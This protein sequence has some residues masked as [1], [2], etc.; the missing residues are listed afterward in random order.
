MVTDE[1]DDAGPQAISAGP[2][3]HDSGYGSM[4]Y[5]QIVES[6]PYIPPRRQSLH[7]TV[8]R[9]EGNAHQKYSTESG[10]TIEPS[11]HLQTPLYED[12]MP[13]PLSPRRPS[14]PAPAPRHEAEE[15]SE[16]AKEVDDQHTSWLNTINES[17]GSSAASVHSRR[18]SFGLRRKRIRPTSGATEADFNAALDAAIEVAYDDGFEPDDEEDDEMDLMDDPQY[19]ADPSDPLSHIRR[20]VELARVNAREAERQAAI[21]Q[22]R[23]TERLQ[24]QSLVAPRNSLDGYGD[25]EG[26]EEER[27]LEEW[28]RDFVLDDTEYSTQ[29]K[30]ALPRESDSSSFSGRTWGSIGSSPMSASLPAVAEVANLPSLST[31]MNEK[32]V[33]P[34]LHPPPSSALPPPPAAPGSGSDTSTN[35]PLNRSAGFSSRGT[36]PGV[37]ERRLSGM[38]AKQLKIET[39]TG[40]Y[41]ALAQ[42]PKTQPAPAVAPLLQA[43]LDAPMS[44]YNTD[45]Y[46]TEDSTPALQS[47]ALFPPSATLASSRKGS[48][49]LTGSDAGEPVSATASAIT[50]V[51]SADSDTLAAS[52]P[53]SPA[54]LQSRGATGLRK[55]FSSSSLRSKSFT[56]GGDNQEASPNTSLSSVGSATR[57]PQ[58]PSPAVPILPTP[59]ETNFLPKAQS[60]AGIYLFDCDIH[61]PNHPGQPNPLA[62]N[63][64]LPLEPC[65]E[66]SLLRPF[67]FLRA[68]YQTIAHPRG[69]YITTKLFVPRDIWRVK[70]L[71]L[72][73]VE[74]KVSTCDLLT[75]A[76]LKLSKV[77]TLNADAVLEEMQFLE[78]IID[79]AKANLSKKL[80]SEVGLQGVAGTFKNAPTLD[81]DAASNTDANPPPSATSSNKSYLKSWR[82][83]RSTKS[84]GVGATPASVARGAGDAS[85]SKEALTM[86]SLPMTTSQNPRFPKRDL[87]QVQCMGPNPSYMGAL[88]RLC[89]A[90]Q[91]LGMQIF[92]LEPPPLALFHADL[93][94]RCTDQIA[95]QVEDPGLKHSS[96]AQVG[97]EFCTRHAADFFGFYICRFVFADIGLMLDKYIKRGGEWVM[98]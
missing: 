55:N 49:P 1:E 51:T 23:S 47:P 43:P 63:A 54:R 91:I 29:T 38:K 64:P 46:L 70:N 81:I 11:M 14:S 96:P 33:P 92:Y 94:G 5:R 83:L 42:A 25:D 84:L 79:R 16:P 35:G 74:E 40:P 98:A 72:K 4:R 75:A 90:A 77:D 36:S 39:N 60:S 56:A 58:V 30:S 9:S 67:W 97:L 27:M 13:P 20:N 78:T 21:S 52:T 88:A 8:Y 18:S 17:S 68:I 87:S 95:R 26:E 69:G 31:Q 15:E 28:T 85:S 62:A 86:P 53:S 6:P 59:A 73:N 89:D 48:F 76:L 61:S 80:G 65:P 34:P 2:V 32:S 37:R 57:I 22:A 93:R 24:Q 7:S 41:G 12:D 19:Q 82:K 71:K 3:G 10:R 45:P 50:K 66:S 44:A